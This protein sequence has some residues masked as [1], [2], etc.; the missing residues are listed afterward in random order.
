MAEGWVLRHFKRKNEYYCTYGKY[1][2]TVGNINC[3]K[4]FKTKYLAEIKAFGVFGNFVAC[5][6]KNQKGRKYE[7]ICN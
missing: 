4:V 1:I 3:A 6:I 5:K 2:Q 7:S